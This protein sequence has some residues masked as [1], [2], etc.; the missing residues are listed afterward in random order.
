MS[1]SSYLMALD[2]RVACAAPSCYLT[3]FR[4]LIDTMGPQDAE[5]N[6]HGQLAFGMDHADYLM[7]RA[8]KPTLILAS[9]QDFFDITGTWD[10]FRQAKR[11]YT[12]LGFA[13][14][15]ELVETDASHGY[16]QRA[17][18]CACG[19]ARR[20]AFGEAANASR[21]RS[22]VKGIVRIRT[23]VAS[24][25]ALP[26]AAG[27]GQMAGSPAPSA[28]SSGRSISATSMAGTSENVRMW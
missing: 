8:P 15:V 2:D 25:M 20:Y 12:R 26:M 21:T 23:P 5:Q 6:I 17:L 16:P 13:E 24:K 28:S 22:G 19:T 1:F 10:T 11:F 18:P 14:R 4:R 27:T 9:T 3:S 7:M